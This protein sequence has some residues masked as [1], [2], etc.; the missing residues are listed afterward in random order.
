M[1]PNLPSTFFGLLTQT[2]MEQLTLG[3]FQLSTLALISTSL[4]NKL[5]LSNRIKWRQ[6]FR[7]YSYCTDWLFLLVLFLLQ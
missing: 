6:F 2:Q 4:F 3:K 5:S 1:R 7:S